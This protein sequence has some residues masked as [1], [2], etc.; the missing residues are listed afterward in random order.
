MVEPKLIYITEAARKGRVARSE[1][2][3]TLGLTETGAKSAPF[4]YV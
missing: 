1:D 2:G 4:I 3:D